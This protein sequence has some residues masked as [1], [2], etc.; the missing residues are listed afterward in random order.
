V[1]ISE[2]KAGQMLQTR[3]PSRHNVQPAGNT[4]TDMQ[5]SDT[6]YMSV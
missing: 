6:T 2:Q 3:E 1:S 4:T 5:H